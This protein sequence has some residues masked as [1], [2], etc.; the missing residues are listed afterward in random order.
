M[1]PTFLASDIQKEW[2]IPR[3]RAWL[4]GLSRDFKV[5]RYDNR[6]VGASQRDP[7][8]VSMKAMMLDLD[9]VVD[10]LRLRRFAVY[11]AT[12][13]APL[14]VKYAIRSPAVSHLILWNPVV[15][16]RDAFNDP[17]TKA[18]LSLA[19]TNWDLFAMASVSSMAGWNV[20]EEIRSYAEIA[21]S[22]G[23]EFFQQMFEVLQD[24]D[25]S[26][27]L[28]R[29]SSE[30]LLLHRKDFKLISLTN[31]H[32]MASRIKRAVLAPIEGESGFNADET[33][34]QAI[35]S[36]LLRETAHRDRCA[37]APGNVELTKREVEVLAS[38][39]SGLHTDAVSHE[40]GIS[41]RTTEHHLAN[42]YEKM[43]VHSRLEAV[44]KW[45]E[46]GNNGRLVGGAPPA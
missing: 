36:F 31:S 16:N 40:L 1:L 20:S 43:E 39:A 37:P 46:T 27:D 30:T 42:I 8:D 32:I 33:V 28:G 23:F 12:Y 38:F 15:R 24:W 4:E 7:R 22:V 18:I 9:A 25:A 5:I 6:G 41:R 34:V 44:L 14:A 35:T 19:R 29:V 26:E 11:A 2:L 17:E 45:L 13:M 10:A 21:R 3:R